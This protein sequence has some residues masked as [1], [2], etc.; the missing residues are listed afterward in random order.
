MTIRVDNKLV[1]GLTYL[2]TGSGTA[3]GIAALVLNTALGKAIKS[4]VLEADP[5]IGYGVRYAFGG[6]SPSTVVGHLLAPGS[7]IVIENPASIKSLLIINAE[8]GNNASVWATP[9]YEK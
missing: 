3:V 7:S 9:Y 8:T 4:L 2:I 1:A 6:L 5:D